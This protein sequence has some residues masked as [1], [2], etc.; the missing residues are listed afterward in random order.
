MAAAL[1]D[2]RV[3][4]L[5]RILAGPS[6]TQILGDLGADIVKIEQ[7]GRGDDT[8]GWG[9]PYLKDGD[10]NDSTEA[11]YY[12]GTN[13]NKRSLTLDISTADGQALARRLIGRCDVL[14]ENYKVGGL[15]KYGLAYDDLKDEFPGLIYC[16]ITGFG[17]TG[18]YAPRPG[19]D[20]L[21]QGMS[22]LMSVTGE[23]DGEPMKVGVPISDLTTGMYSTVAIL[24]ALHHRDRTGAGQHI[25]MSL[26]DAQIGW[27]YNQGMNYLVGGR[28]PHRRGN[29]HP[30]VGPCQAYQSKDGDFTVMIGNDDQ[31]RKLCVLAGVPEV[32]D[33]PRFARNTGRMTN[34]EA[35]G[36]IL[37]PIFKTR[38]TDDWLAAFEEFKIGAGPINTVAQVF[39]DAHVQSRGMRISMPHEGAGGG[40]VDMIASP[41]KMSE[42]P[43][44]YRH[45]PPMLGQHTDELL[46]ELLDMDPAEVTA[47]RERKVV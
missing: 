46:R 3:F 47:L 5:T 8:R 16:S 26:L 11:A 44:G 20:F 33:D 43:P 1:E 19:Y 27:L 18:P 12:L 35:L 31:F 28:N 9:P 24:A 39:D 13:R 2:I 4:D 23:A 30:N 32:A 40:P 7:P 10:G 34:F 41:I 38:T 6:C 25:D 36:D 21:I 15:A 29:I 45:P 22:G 17:Q 37:E 42:T 14:V